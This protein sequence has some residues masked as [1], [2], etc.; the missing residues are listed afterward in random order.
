MRDS[1]ATLAISILVK[2]ITWFKRF[3]LAE[4]ITIFL[5]EITI[6]SLS[7]SDNSYVSDTIPVSV[8]FGST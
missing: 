1:S 4:T 3:Q 8:V 6:T 2:T 7:Y 5:W